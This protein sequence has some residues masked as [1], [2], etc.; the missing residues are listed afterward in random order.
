MTVVDVRPAT[1]EEIEAA[2]KKIEA[3]QQ[4][5]SSEKAYAAGSFDP[6]GGAAAK[7]LGLDDIWLEEKDIDALLDADLRSRRDIA[8]QKLINDE[9]SPDTVPPSIKMLLLDLQYNNGLGDKS[10]RKHLIDPI[11]SRDWQRVKQEVRKYPISADRDRRRQEYVDE[12]IQ[13]DAQR[14]RQ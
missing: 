7:E 6:K 9:I 1:A 3:F 12:A 13:W 8:M 5:A 14:A 4:P 11:R 2:F 10:A